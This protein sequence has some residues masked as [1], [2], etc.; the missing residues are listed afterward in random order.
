MCG[1]RQK[2]ITAERK[3]KKYD[4]G[5]EQEK[6]KKNKKRKKRRKARK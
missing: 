5:S 6:K 2:D 3:G 4:N 1:R